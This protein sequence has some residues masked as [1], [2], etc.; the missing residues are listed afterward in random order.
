[1]A[2]KQAK[3]ATR[4]D[5]AIAGALLGAGG[6]VLL[7]PIDGLYQSAKELFWNG[8]NGMINTPTSWLVEP[9]TFLLI[10]G[11]AAI[12]GIFGGKGFIK[13]D[14][15]D[16]KLYKDESDKEDFKKDLTDG[17]ALYGF[18]GSALTTITEYGLEHLDKAQKIPEYLSFLK[19][20]EPSLSD[21]LA[22]S[23]PL[24]LAGG[25]MYASNKAFERA[26][27]KTDKQKNQK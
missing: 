4:L 17:F 16:Y 3:I 11:G 13:K 2:E 26:S 20:V 18:L 22:V 27:E 19:G 23:L 7:G 10:T 6:S 25:Y 5:G 8:I 15:V 12:G 24:A 1:M 21:V 9:K 14:G